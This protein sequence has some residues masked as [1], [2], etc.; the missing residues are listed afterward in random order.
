[1]SAP[2]STGPITWVS[3]EPASGAPG[4]MITVTLK[5]PTGALCEITFINPGT[6]TR[7]SRK[8]DPVTADADGNAVLSWNTHSEARA[9]CCGT[10]ELTVTETDGTKT[11]ETQ[12]YEL[13]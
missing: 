4:D 3:T 11:I 10:I 2:V 5:V 8:P 12:P 13:K 9:E 7:S 6:G 1:M